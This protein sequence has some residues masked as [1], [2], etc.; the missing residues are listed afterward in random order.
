MMI[1]HW[2]ITTNL[3]VVILQEILVGVNAEIALTEI[4]WSLEQLNTIYG[5]PFHE[6]S[7][8]IHFV[9]APKQEHYLWPGDEKEQLTL[10]CWSS[11]RW[12]SRPRKEDIYIT[13]YNRHWYVGQGGMDAMR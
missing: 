10:S 1:C 6:D 11:L 2:W 8:Q 7:S 3:L 4:P 9:P 12:L 13:P 5:I